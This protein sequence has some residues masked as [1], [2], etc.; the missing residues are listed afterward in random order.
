MKNYDPIQEALEYAES[1]I[2]DVINGNND[3]EQ[4]LDH[5]TVA[6]IKS[7]FYIHDEE[8]GKTED[9]IP[10]VCDL[11]EFVLDNMINAEENYLNE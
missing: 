7:Y 4:L 8:T 1:L 6:D 5:Y 2:Q 3:W 11:A 10:D 9:I